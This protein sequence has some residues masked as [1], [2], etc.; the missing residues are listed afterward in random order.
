MVCRPPPYRPFGI[1]RLVLALMVLVQHGLL[2]LGPAARDMFYD[3]ELGS[4]AVTTFFALSGFIVAEATQ[5][6]YA[7]PR[8][9]PLHGSP[10]QPRGIL[11][12][13]REGVPGLPA[14]RISGQDFSFIPFAWTLRV[15][16]AF[17]LA[18]FVTSWLILRRRPGV[19]VAALALALAYACFA[20]FVLR[21]GHGPL[22]VICIPFFAFGVGVY[23]H[24]RSSTPASVL[25]LVF[26]SACVL[27]AFPY[28]RQHGHPVV[29]LQQ[30]LIA[31][32]YAVLLAL[33]RVHAVSQRFRRW[34]RR[35]GELSY[36]LYISHGIVLTALASISTRRGAGPYAE[37]VLASLALAAALHLAVE[38]PLRSVRT[39][40]RGAA[41]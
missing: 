28:F 11:A 35:L 33:S 40:L 15:E 13:V 39:R 26:A 37:A 29:A 25:H 36:P 21:G 7:G 32:L 8:D 24:D 16:F 2:L 34:D 1:F 17:Y 22:Q 31:A 10:G 23:A 4:V 30:A 19:P 18:A 12:A 6:F 20:A 41:V 5:R 14:N 3:L 27:L 38:Q 9:V